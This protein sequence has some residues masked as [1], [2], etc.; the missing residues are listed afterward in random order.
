VLRGEMEHTK[1]FERIYHR[2]PVI[3]AAPYMDT[4]LVTVQWCQYFEN[5][6]VQY[7]YNVMKPCETTYCDHLYQRRLHGKKR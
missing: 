1:G 4:V 2:Y 6:M 7:R 5:N 3:D